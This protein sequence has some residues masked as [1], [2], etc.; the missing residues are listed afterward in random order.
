[1]QTAGKTSRFVTFQIKA[2]T[3]FGD[4]I[5]VVGGQPALGNWDPWAPAIPELTTTEKDY[6]LWRTP[7]VEL[8]FDFDVHYKYVRLKSDGR[9]E[10]ETDGENRTV[11]AGGAKGNI[12]VDDEDFGTVR[13]QPFGFLEGANLQQPGLSFA[14]EPATNGP[15]IVVLGDAVA[16]GYGAWCFNGWTAKLGATLR[17]RYGYGFTNLSEASLNAQ[18]ALSRRLIQN[19]PS[20]PPPEVVLLA[21][22]LELRDLVVCPDWDRGEICARHMSALS[23]LVQAVWDL[24][25]MPVVCGVVPHTDLSRELAD[26]LRNGDQALKR[27]G[28]PVLEWLHL[29][30]KNGD[31]GTMTW[32]DGL[33][34]DQ[35]QPS[36][37]GHERMFLA[38]DLSIF[39]PAK[40][41]ATLAKRASSLKTEKACFEDGKGFEVRYAIA[42]SELILN[43]RTSTA[44]TFSAGWDALQSAMQ[45]AFWEVPWSL[46]KGLYVRTS[47]ETVKGSPF[48]ACLGQAGQVVGEVAVP[49]NSSTRLQHGLPI[50]LEWKALF[51]DGKLGLLY[52][53]SAAAVRILNYEGCEYNVH[54]MWQDVRLA[55]RKLEEG[56]YED[57]SGQ[58][59]RTAV[60][61]A[62]GLQSRVK[63]PPTSAIELRRTGDL[64]SITRIAVLPLGDR[65]SIRMLLHKVEYD[66][67]CYPF[68]LT[69]TTSL[70]DVADM[71][72]T[73]FTDMWNQDLLWYDHEAGRIFHRK[74]Q[75]LSYAHEV[76]DEDDPVNNFGPVAERMWKRY[77]G[78]AARFDWACTH[79]DEVMFMRTGCASRGE[80]CDLMSRVKHRFPT[81]KAKLLLISDQPT[82]EFKDLE[83]VKHIREAFDPDRMHEDKGYWIHSAHRFR[84]I[85][86]GI[87]INARS[88][89]WCPNNLK[90]AEKELVEASEASPKIELGTPTISN[91]SEI[92]KLSHANLY[93]LKGP[94]S[95]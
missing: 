73:G 21:F 66:G 13:P 6:P 65:C 4:K 11:P 24:G 52:N 39:D 85:L 91:T 61:S 2:Q 79:A 5:V 84:C 59:F 81:I 47:K 28:V 18:Q 90:E 42:T 7:P 29:L 27:L 17:E 67:P 43:N 44:Y 50:S 82:E 10:W 38:I 58:Q 83:N 89:Y 8:S 57:E 14:L 35:A 68:D 16:A 53:K 70:S 60:I 15:R 25:A 37:K 32:A 45:A 76:E 92:A 87:G 86:D 94:L 49:P 56:I 80:V 71:I 62:H 33:N 12:V 93:D 40:V 46:K 74:W 30:C 95:P 41:K 22:S 64:S 3:D 77:S 26:S 36:T 69:R 31:G 48:S 20:N 63:V 55:T 1:M 78:R 34:F 51:S 72:A 88:L 54:P 19:L 23:S 75:G 9:A